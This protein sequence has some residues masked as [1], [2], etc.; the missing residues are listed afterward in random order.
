MIYQ[1]HHQSK[2]DGNTEFIAQSDDIIEDNEEA[3][4]KFRQWSLD[5]GIEHPLPE[6]YQ[7]LVCNERSE[8]FAC[9]FNEES[10]S[11]PK[12]KRLELVT[13]RRVND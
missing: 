1:I 4:Q 11:K 7:W 6:G 2:K 10:V 8:H 9:T 12:R 5:V 3:Q 13:K